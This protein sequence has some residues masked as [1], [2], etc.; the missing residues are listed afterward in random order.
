MFG[1]VPKLL[2]DIKCG[3]GGETLILSQMKKVPMGVQRDG[4]AK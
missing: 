3:S 2:D 4:G 1:N